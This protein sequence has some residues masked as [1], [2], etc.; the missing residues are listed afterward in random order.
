MLTKLLSI[1]VCLLGIATG[2]LGQS[3]FQEL[4]PGTSIRNDV[5]RV[6]GQPVQI[7]DATRFEYAPPAGIAKIEVQYRAGSPIV[8][9]I[10]VY[11]L[12]PITRAALIQKFSLPQQADAIKKM[13]EEG[14]LAEYFGGSST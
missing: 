7:V 5:D 9:R 4:T 13:T 11:L 1:T 14:K 3:S 8:E 6:L 2:C 10:K 12:K